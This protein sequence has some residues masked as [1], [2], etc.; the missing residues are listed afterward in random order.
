[1]A[2]TTDANTAGGRPKGI[3]AAWVL[4]LAAIVGQVVV[5]VLGSFV[6]EPTGL[7]ELAAASGP[8]AAARRLA[9]SGG[10]LA[11]FLAAWLAVALR[12]RAGRGWARAV[13]GVA[14]VAS[15]LFVA[16]DLRMNGTVPGAWELLAGFPDLLAAAAVI[17]MYLPAARTRFQARR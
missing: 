16:T 6:V 3:E 13:L 7:D 17:P 12:M 11:V 10:V 5:W 14:G 8:G 15:L 2:T 4:T 9:L 1:M